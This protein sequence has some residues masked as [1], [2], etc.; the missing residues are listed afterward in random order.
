M[1]TITFSRFIVLYSY[2]AQDENDLS[3]ER[4]QCVTVLN[5][6]TN[7][8]WFGC[9]VLSMILMVLMDVKISVMLCVTVLNKVTTSPFSVCWWRKSW[10]GSWCWWCRL[11]DHDGLVGLILTF[12]WHRMILNAS[13]W[14]G[15]MPRR[16][17]YLQ[18]EN[19]LIFGPANCDIWPQQIGQANCDTYP[20][21]RFCISTGRDTAE[22]QT[23]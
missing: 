18:V 6:V 20:D 21:H 2:H 17:L 14:L 5:K 13:G 3:V 1:I 16:D 23:S 7:V 4:G 9:W 12:L 11:D 8:P 22:Q 19:L 10:Q 15:L